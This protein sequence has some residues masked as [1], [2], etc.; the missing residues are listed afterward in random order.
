VRR[1][2]ADGVAV[3][4]IGRMEVVGLPSLDDLLTVGD[5]EADL[6]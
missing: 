1:E 3:E 6:G 5:V 2:E 4:V